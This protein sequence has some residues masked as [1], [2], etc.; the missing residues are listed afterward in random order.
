MNSIIHEHLQRPLPKRP[1]ASDGFKDGPQAVWA[2]D[3]TPENSSEFAP[4]L[5]APKPVKPCDRGV[6]EAL[7]LLLIREQTGGGQALPDGFGFAR[8]GLAALN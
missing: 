3:Q 4:G 2:A 6:F 8:L 7:N 1:A 5:I